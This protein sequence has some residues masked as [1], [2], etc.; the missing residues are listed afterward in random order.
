MHR[1]SAMAKNSLPAYS[2]P[3]TRQKARHLI[4][5]THL[6]SL[7][8]DIDFALSDGN[9]ATAAANIV[10]D[11]VTDPNP[12]PPLWY[13]NGSSSGIDEIYDMQ[14][15][16]L[17]AMR[18]KGLIEKMT[19]FW[20]NHMPTSW[21][22]NSAK[23]NHSAA[24]LSYDYYSLLRTHALGNFKE[25]VYRIG[26]NASMHY[27]LDGY[28]NEKGAANENF[29]REL[30][31][32]FT[33][34]QYAPDSSLNY[35]ENDIKE[36]ARALTGWV[37]SNNREVVFV[38]SRHDTGTKSFLGQTGSYGYDDVIDIV[39]NERQSEIAHYVCK[40]LYA[41]FVSA[42]PDETV[43]A[44]LASTFTANNF[45]IAPV[46]L[47]LLSSDHFYSDRFV[48]ARIKS[49]LEYVVGFVREG[50]VIPTTQLLD[51]IRDLLTPIQ[52]GQELHNPPNVA[53]W[54]G[55][56]PPD[57]SGIPGH[58]SWLTT[59]TL[60]D[61][62]RV[63]NDLIFDRLGTAFDPIDVVLKISDPSDPFRIAIDLAEVF[64]PIPLEETGIR[65]VREPFGGNPDIP[66]P[67]EIANGPAYVR[68]LSKILLDGSPFYE[69]PLI[70]DETS[71]GVVDARRLIRSY[72]AYLIQLPAY[73]LT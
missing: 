10:N 42:M 34:G 28:V 30:L 1:N 33:M 64:L 26:K 16:W 48:G 18:T 70:V 38:G 14:R 51:A 49:P 41:F 65:E 52:L 19:L 55:M 56:N 7:K 66:I 50:E 5:R 44:S 57:S 61:R 35:T 22:T 71:E 32:L 9:A 13:Q 43:V 53:G 58:H 3:W 29:A 37:V 15:Q 46:M 4:S 62:W 73:Q 12:E 31:E 2:G 68:N 39:F 24:H 69:W 8:R 25:M 63:L 17:D 11:A 21:T 59:T 67:D 72:M 20:H 27:Y 60:P 40:K 23:S 36:I 54:P 6:G 47:E 45:D